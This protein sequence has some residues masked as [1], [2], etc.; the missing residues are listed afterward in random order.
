M[1]FSDKGVFGTIG[2]LIIAFLAIAFFIKLLPIILIM[3]VAIWGI[4]KLSKL[5]ESKKNNKFV[6]NEKS[7]VSEVSKDDDVF[8]FEKQD[9][10]DVDYTEI[11]K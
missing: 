7:N 9:V 6:N 10:V 5:F 3:G 11:K 1:S 2:V 4:V 8:D